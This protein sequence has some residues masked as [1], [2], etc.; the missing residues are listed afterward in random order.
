LPCGRLIF[1]RRGELSSSP[2]DKIDSNTNNRRY[3]LRSDPNI[4][5]VPPL[6]IDRRVRNNPAVLLAGLCKCD[7]R[8]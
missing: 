5:L 8:I 4:I 7:A 6:R 2:D 1:S 3:P